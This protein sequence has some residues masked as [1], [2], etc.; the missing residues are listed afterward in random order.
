VRGLALSGYFPFFASIYVPRLRG[1]RLIRDP[2]IKAGNRGNF[3]LKSEL[4]GATGELLNSY[5]IK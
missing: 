3:K 1:F 4:E 5:I 2:G